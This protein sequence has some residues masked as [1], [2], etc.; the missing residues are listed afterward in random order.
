MP[1]VRYSAYCRYS[2]TQTSGGFTL[3]YASMFTEEKG[4]ELP[5]EVHWPKLI[6]HI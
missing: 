4:K 5:H 2:G 1:I 3:A 6:G